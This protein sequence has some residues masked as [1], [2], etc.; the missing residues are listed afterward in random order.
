MMKN[1]VFTHKIL[2]FILTLLL[3]NTIHSFAQTGTSSNKLPKMTLLN[4]KKIMGD[5]FGAPMVEIKK[6]SIL[7]YDGFNTMEGVGAMVV[8]SELMNV[9][10]EY[11][12]INE[13]WV[14]GDFAEIFVKNTLGDIKKTDLLFIPG[15]TGDAL[16]SVMSNSE[17]IEWIK[18]I[19]NRSVITAGS[20]NGVY[21]LGKAGLLQGK[22]IASSWFFG[23]ENAA[24]FNAK[25]QQDRYLNDGKLWTSASSTAA[26]DMCLALIGHMNGETFLQAAMLDLE[27]DPHP[28]ITAGN[29][30]TTTKPVIDFMQADMLQVDGLNILNDKQIINLS[31]NL[32]NSSITTK[33]DTIGILA[34]DG[35][36][37]LDV[38]G[39]LTTLSLLP[40]TTVL[41]IG[42]GEN[43]VKSGRS[44]FKLN[45]NIA[46]I[47][48]LDM[49]LVPGGS[50]GTWKTAQDTA[51][52]NW[53]KTIDKNSVYTT[54]VCTGAWVLGEAGLITGKSATTHWYRK[55]EM[56]NK[57][58]ANTQNLRYV[59]DGKYW[60]SA[61]VSAGIDFSFAIIDQIAGAT[62]TEYAMLKAEYHPQSPIIGGTPEKSN[63][64]VVDMMMQ[65]YD[66]MMYDL[67]FNGK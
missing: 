56:L 31:S 64:L 63:P 25:Y 46:T 41:L 48:H 61:G 6:V 5:L 35:F 42:Q 8:F 34:Y 32:I 38:L 27:Y 30:Q 29:I 19:D 50:S 17:V 60:T 57:Y 62:F 36:F 67:L 28:H 40:N 1:F 16:S 59:Q 24:R 15:C 54:S 9:D 51:V 52:T 47:K 11:V 22:S 4:H 21:L 20:G 26:L 12:S 10:V 43:E 45:G 65:M 13:G 39:P 53:I 23:E 7:V 44:I 49:V 37:T 18:K 58:Q 33:I 2:V 55:T 14:K 3:G 66:Y